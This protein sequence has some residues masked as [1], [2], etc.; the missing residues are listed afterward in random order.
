MS[1]SAQEGWSVGVEVT[2]NL[3]WLYNKSD[4]NEQTYG[5][6]K[7]PDLFPPNGIQAGLG[8]KYTFNEHIEAGVSLLYAYGKQKYEYIAPTNTNI[9]WN[10]FVEMKHLKL[11]LSIT[12]LFV[13]SE[14]NS[15]FLETGIMPTYLVEGVEHTSSTEISGSSETHF[16]YEQRN[17]TFTARE[18]HDFNLPETT[19]TIQTKS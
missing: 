17:T 18:K 4:W 9:T 7:E 2:P 16:I 15:F 5:R 1:A 19:Y 6:G 12:Y 13:N 14:N 11:P 3:F 8:A 10:N